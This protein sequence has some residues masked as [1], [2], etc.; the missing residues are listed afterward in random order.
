MNGTRRRAEINA[1]F[2]WVWL[3]GLLLLGLA[4]WLALTSDITLRLLMQDATTVLGAPFYIGSLSMAGIIGWSLAVGVSIFTAIAS[5]GHAP[6]PWR[7]FL[8]AMGG[9]TA[10][11]LVDD[12][13]LLHDEIVPQY[14]GISGELVGVAYVILTVV[15]LYRFRDVVRRSNYILLGAAL[16]LLGVSA[17]VDV[18]S[19]ALANVLAGNAIFLAEDGTKLIG[20]WTW[21][22]YLA[23]VSLQALRNLD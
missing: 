11:L 21:L 14:V 16:A 5:T 8:L 1:T 18:G 4:L 6:R 23:S 19:S 3:P 20:T 12:A 17:A 9:L 2:L 22:A 10:L 15:I 13:Y 7:S